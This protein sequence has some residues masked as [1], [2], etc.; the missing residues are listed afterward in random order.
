MKYLTAQIEKLKDKK[1]TAKKQKQAYHAIINPLQEI[2][3]AR[4]LPIEIPDL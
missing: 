3:F 4:F 2:L 1:Q